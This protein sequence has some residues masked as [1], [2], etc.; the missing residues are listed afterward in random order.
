MKKVNSGHCPDKVG[1]QIFTGGVPY[2]SFYHILP[3]DTMYLG[4]KNG[5]EIMLNSKV[6]SIEGNAIV[7]AVNVLNLKTGKEKRFPTNAVFISVG[8]VPMT[9]ITQKAGVDVDENG[10]IKVD[11]RQRTNVEGV[12]AAGNCGSNCPDGR[13]G[14]GNIGP[15]NSIHGSNSHPEIISVAAVTIN[16]DLLGYSSEGPGKLSAQKPDIS[17]FSHFSGSGVYSVDSGTS[18]ACPVVGGV[19]AALRSVPNGRNLNP[20]EIKQKI[21]DTARSVHGPG[22]SPQYGWGIV[23]ADAAYNVL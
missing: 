22:W 9:D 4:E 20:A 11:H 6:K 21:F 12:F 8:S 7:E 3:H 17:G 19:L 15:N 23:D 13:C 2:S 10:C 18:A 16:D 1:N 14:S 5:F